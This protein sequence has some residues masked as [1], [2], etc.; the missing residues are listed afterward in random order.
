ME[1]VS[2]KMRAK[3]IREM[4]FEQHFLTMFE[5]HGLTLREARN[6]VQFHCYKSH[7]DILTS[8]K[9]KDNQLFFIVYS[10]CSTV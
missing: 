3:F 6:R 5:N 9:L 4:R 2:K 1:E 8:T 10:T 7:L